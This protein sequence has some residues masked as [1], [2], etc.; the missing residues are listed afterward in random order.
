MSS[1]KSE[2]KQVTADFLFEWPKCRT[3][4]T[5]NAVEDVEQQEFLLI[6]GAGKQN[7]T[8]TLEG[9]LSVAHKTKHLAYDPAMMRFGIYPKGSKF[10]FMG[11]FLAALF[12]KAQTWKKTKI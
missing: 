7:D 6:A 5:P 2:L 12:I 10:T 9:H 3:L 11:M 8:A 1:E 4:T